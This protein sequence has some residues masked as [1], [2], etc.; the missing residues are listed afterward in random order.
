MGSERAGTPV[1]RTI[2]S[3]TPFVCGLKYGRALLEQ[4][5]AA[6]EKLAACKEFLNFTLQQLSPLCLQ[7]HPASYGAV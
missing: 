1:C 3:V 6:N 5:K 7:R 2:S 4:K